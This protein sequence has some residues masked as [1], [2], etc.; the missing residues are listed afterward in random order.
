MLRLWYQHQHADRDGGIGSCQRGEMLPL[1]LI[2]VGK[3]KDMRGEGLLSV[4]SRGSVA[5]F[6]EQSRYLGHL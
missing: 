6:E 3:P 5:R 1:Q 2:Q 4:L